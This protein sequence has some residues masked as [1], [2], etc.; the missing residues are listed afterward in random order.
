MFRKILQL[1][2]THQRQST[3]Q[4]ETGYELV[5]W[6]KKIEP[7]DC[8]TPMPKYA[9]FPMMCMLDLVDCYQLL[10]VSHSFRNSFTRYIVPCISNKPKLDYQWANLYWRSTQSLSPDFFPRFLVLKTSDQLAECKKNMNQMHGFFINFPEKPFSSKNFRKLNLSGFFSTT[11]NWPDYTSRKNAIKY[12]VEQFEKLFEKQKFPYVEKLVLINFVYSSKLRKLLFE[13]F[14]GLKTFIIKSFNFNSEKLNISL[15]YLTLDKLEITLP[16]LRHFNLLPPIQLG[17]ITINS[18]QPNSKTKTTRCQP[19]R[20]YI[21]ASHCESLN[22]VIINK[23]PYDPNMIDFM[24]PF[25]LENLFFFSNGSCFLVPDL[26]V[27][28]D[29]YC[30]P[31]LRKIFVG[32]EKNEL[33]FIQQKL[34]ANGNWRLYDERCPKC[35]EFGVYDEFGNTYITWKKQ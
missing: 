27:C 35:I 34:D 33:R 26:S 6:T 21:D 3:R 16:T 18:L 29:L 11:I 30:Y 23:N 25:C 8:F 17:T 19:K 13:T 12:S 20:Q 7:L 2:P 4:P 22:T 5:T 1:Q 14:N 31:N 24:Y 32:G 10:M 15:M 9:I 28:P